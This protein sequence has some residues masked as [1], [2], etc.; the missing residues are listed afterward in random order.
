VFEAI[1]QDRLQHPG[2]GKLKHCVQTLQ[3]NDSVNKKNNC[4]FNRVF[5][6]RIFY[7]QER[8][9]FFSEYALLL[10]RALKKFHPN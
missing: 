6:K 8:C 9:Y 7:L 4:Q 10:K 5:G 1:Q 3:M 2:P